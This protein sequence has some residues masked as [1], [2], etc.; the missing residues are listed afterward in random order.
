MVSV[1]LIHNLRW[2]MVSGTN[3]LWKMTTLLL[4]SL[5]IRKNYLSNQHSLYSV[6]YIIHIWKWLSNTNVVYYI[7]QGCHDGI[8]IYSHAVLVRT[9][10]KV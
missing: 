4:L 10:E 3:V 2:R 7:A 5:S 1:A 9:R 8:A 6:C